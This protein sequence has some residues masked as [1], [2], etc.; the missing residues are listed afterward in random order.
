MGK[1]IHVSK[2]GSD[3]ATGEKEFPF[4]TISKAAETA[5]SGDTVI[6]HEGTYREWVR[7]QNSGKSNRCRIT[8][9]AAEGEHV[10]IKGSERISNWE[11][12]EGSVWKAVI[13]NT[14]FGEWNPFAETIEGDWMVAPQEYPV[15]AGD[16]YLNGKS[17]YEARS[18]EEVKR[19]EK[20]E[21]GC[22][23]EFMPGDGKIL[24]PEDTVYLWFAEVQTQDTIL[25]A[26]FQG[27]DPNKE[28][29]EIN[30]RKCCF[31][32]DMPGR[33]YITVRGFEMAQAATIW[34]PPTAS[35]P[36]LIG[37]HWSRGW[38]IENNDIHDAKCSAVSLGRAD[39][40]ENGLCSMEWKKPGYQYQLE[41]VF[42]AQQEGWAR[43]TIGSHIVRGN[44]I[45]DCGQNAI[46][47]HMGCVFSEIYDNHIYDIAIKQEFFGYEIA[48]IKLHAAIDVQIRHN[49]IHDCYMGI[50][51]DWEAQGARVSRN[52]FNQNRKDLMVEVT[53]GP[54]IVDNN[55]FAS[56]YNFD[57]VSQGGAYVHNLCCG[58][59]RRVAVPDRATMYHFPHTT[60]VAGHAIIYSGDD[61]YY[62]NIFVGGPDGS[63]P[64][65]SVG[66]CG[67]DGSPASMEEYTER[68]LCEPGDDH[69]RFA[70]VKQPV[71]VER[72]IYFN[73]AGAYEREE[74]KLILQ[75]NPNVKII[76]ENGDFYL[77][78]EVPNQFLEFQTQLIDSYD[79][80]PPRISEA[81]FEDPNGE[82][83][84][85]HT[86]L[87]GNR[88]GQ[89]P[90]AGPIECLQAGNNKIKIW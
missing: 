25:Y 60:H 8:Y 34:A 63:Q 90:C 57:N 15:H 36:G 28:L 33:N 35:Q 54:Y 41:C 79:F 74:N 89:W 86:D 53:H 12:I 3:T 82:S 23:P 31:Y 39:T 2:N 88:R 80:Q 22:N 37:P 66:T 27:A 70:T 32:P 59:I 20:R 45:H 78:M 47:G 26:N 1:L 18:L 73:G 5:Q 19:A 64:N 30:V 24:R 85:F 42:C 50:W 55:I 14:L 72:N 13:P 7:P 29:T 40:T 44:R 67:Y 52:I 83:I 17:F 21:K 61:R 51:L 10:V 46:V 11:K 58:V 43:E 65:F 56:A 9:M 76:E 77:E 84:K 62:Q 4:R 68:V 69:V 49:L 38:I 87:M 6:V 71:Y 81:E 75:E 16:V 48:A